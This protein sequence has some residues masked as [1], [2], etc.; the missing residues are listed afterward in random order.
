[1]NSKFSKYVFF[2]TVRLLRLEDII[3][4][5]SIVREVQSFSPNHLI[6]YQLDRL[7]N[8]FRIS[9][10]I[11]YYNKLVSNIV[12][13]I[14]LKYE[15]VLSSLPIM[16]KRTFTSLGI[17]LKNNK[18]HRHI[19]RST[20]GSTGAPFV[21]V[22]DRFSTAFQDAVMYHTYSWHGIKIGDSQARFWGVP[23]QPKKRFGAFVKDILMNRKRLSAFD[24]SDSA[25]LKYHN[26]LNKFKPKYFYGYPSII[27]Q[28]ALFCNKSKSN[29]QGFELKA[30]IVTGEKV[31]RSQIEYIE[32]VFKTKVVQEYGNTEVGV[33][34]FECSHGNMHEMS[35]NIIV[36]ILK[37]GNVVFDQPGEIVVTE[38][39][40]RSYPFI[41]YKTGDIGIK[42]THKCTCGINYPLIRITEG[43]KDDFIRTPDGRIVYDAILAYILGKYSQHVLSF[44]AIQ[45]Q[46]NKIDIYYVKNIEFDES[47]IDQCVRILNKEVSNLIC[48][49]FICVDSIPVDES[50][51]LRY[52]ISE[53]KD[54]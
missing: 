27:Y 36:E 32:T 41:R 49:N 6:K 18:V 7:R 25:L 30:I 24:I 5:I 42:Y 17:D 26:D 21:F 54:Y 11:P 45:K 3:L 53:L 46:L 15:P 16:D 34:G 14:N 28:F 33:I 47:I 40:A 1:M 50:G 9:T 23:I 43:R 29:F 52:F 13:G 31:V 35:S 12:N 4:F 38:L 51:K 22:K 44:K 39:N 19:E 8:L 2:Y 20:S 37:D 48:F 10:N